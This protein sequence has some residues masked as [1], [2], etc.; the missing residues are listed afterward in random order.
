MELGW[1]QIFAEALL[2][3][4]A[5]Y[6]LKLCQAGKERG[7]RLQDERFAKNSAEIRA[8]MPWAGSP[9]KSAFRPKVCTQSRW[10]ALRNPFL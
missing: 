4:V 2:R 6:L 3:L 10:L 8:A 1:L 7:Q 5:A 9:T